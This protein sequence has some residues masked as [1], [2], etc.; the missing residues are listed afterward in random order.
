MTPL[1]PPVVGDVSHDR[2][3]NGIPDTHGTQDVSDRGGIQSENDIVDRDGD[4]VD[5]ILAVSVGEL[6][7]PKGDLFLNWQVLVLFDGGGFC[8]CRRVFRRV[9]HN[10]LIKGRVG[11]RGICWES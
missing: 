3:C 5:T 11:G 4:V 8:I 7:G 1:T 2:I 9:A 6:A 10:V